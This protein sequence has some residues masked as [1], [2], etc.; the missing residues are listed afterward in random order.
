MEL[1]RF[2]DGRTSVVVFPT[3]AGRFFDY[4]NWG[5]VDAS[6]EALE[7]GRFSLYCVDSIDAKALHCR[8][9]HPRPRLLRHIAYERYVLD[10]VLPFVCAKAQTPPVVTHGCSIGAYHAVNLALRHPEHFSRVVALSG[11][12]DLTKAI[13][14]FDDLFGG[15]YDED[16]HF[17]T[18]SHFV[19]N[20]TDQQLLAHL[21]R[22]DITLAVGE[23]DPFCPNT[24]DLSDALRSKGIQHRL[25]IW[26]GEAHGA[27]AWREM[28][29]RDL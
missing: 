17:Q 18:P 20:I 19:P 11:R 22:L 3:R 26:H 8:H 4:E 27:Q 1:L 15:Y 16:V 2:G 29:Q 23:A 5:L 14:P 28:V 21:R 9:G 10:E 12:Y 13:G 7:A 24:C 6:R 25:V